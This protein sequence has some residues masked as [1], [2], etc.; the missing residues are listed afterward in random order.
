MAMLL[1]NEIFEE[2]VELAE[3][4]NMVGS[5]EDFSSF[6]AE[7]LPQ[8]YLSIL[9]TQLQI[10]LADV[11]EDRYQAS[12]LK[13][14][15]EASDQD[16]EDFDDGSCEICERFVSRTRHHL[17]PRE[18]H[19]TLTHKY[20]KVELGRTIRI[21]RMCHST[22]H[23][24]FSNEQLAREFHTIEAL[25]DDERMYKYAKWAAAQP[26]GASKRVR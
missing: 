3:E 12:I 7:Y 10:N 17:I 11:W 22:I 23:R 16:R 4:N 18:L 13:N 2:T 6:I 26:S 15:K 14:E 9:E 21:C 8:E 20:S 25:L 24:F 5:P 1:V 19:K